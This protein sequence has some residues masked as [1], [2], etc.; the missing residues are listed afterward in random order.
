MT[1]SAYPHHPAATNVHFMWVEPIPYVLLPSVPTPGVARFQGLSPFGDP[2]DLSSG[3]ASFAA[4]GSNAP[5]LRGISQP[6]RTVQRSGGS[7]AHHPSMPPIKE[8]PYLQRDIDGQASDQTQWWGLV[9][10]AAAQSH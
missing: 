8:S 10:S 2:K 3:D 5:L 1:P 6:H 4:S 7:T 9:K